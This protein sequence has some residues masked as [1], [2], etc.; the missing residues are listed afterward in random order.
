MMEAIIR[1]HRISF[2]VWFHHKQ[3]LPFQQQVQLTRVSKGASMLLMLRYS[4]TLPSRS[5]HEPF[6]A[7][8]DGLG[9]FLD[10][11]ISWDSLQDSLVL[12]VVD[13]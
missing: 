3:M 12:I 8:R 2:P 4:Y 7:F 13:D 6:Q 10:T 11:S 5:V 1:I 9:D